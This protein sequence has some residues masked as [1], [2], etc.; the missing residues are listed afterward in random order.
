MEGLKLEMQK[1]FSTHENMIR[2]L[3]ALIQFQSTN[4]FDQSYLTRWVEA[5]SETKGE[6]PERIALSYLS[7]LT[8]NWEPFFQLTMNTKNL[9]LL[10][11]KTLGYVLINRDDLAKSKSVNEMKWIDEENCLTVLSETFALLNSQDEL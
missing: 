1:L 6:L 11:I 10:S 7:F 8:A 3:G 4:K 5:L 2:A 9:E